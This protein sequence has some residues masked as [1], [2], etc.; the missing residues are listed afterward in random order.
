MELKQIYRDIDK[1][2][3]KVRKEIVAAGGKVNCGPRCSACCRD[4]RYFV[5][6]PVSEPEAALMAEALDG[7]CE[8]ARERVLAQHFTHH[9][10]YCV[11]LG[12]N[13]CLIYPGRP[14]RCRIYGLPGSPW[15]CKLNSAPDRLP[16]IAAWAAAVDKALNGHAKLDGGGRIGY[17][18]IVEKWRK[19]NA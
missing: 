8:D 16:G 17:Y 11:F 18:D 1:A 7:L 19:T 10:I 14:L 9:G 4:K 13:G 15:E 5:Q 12:M 2:W 6:L 3:A